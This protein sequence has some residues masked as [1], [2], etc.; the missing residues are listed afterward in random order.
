M[1]TE[2]SKKFFSLRRK[3]AVI[4]CPEFVGDFLTGFGSQKHLHEDPEESFV[5][6]QKE[7]CTTIFATT[8]ILLQ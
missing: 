2:S 6:C 5:D 7:D 8:N 3:S 1:K 4:F